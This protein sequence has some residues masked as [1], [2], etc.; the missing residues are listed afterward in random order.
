M[1][2]QLPFKDIEFAYN[3]KTLKG[4]HRTDKLRYYVLE[5]RPKFCA[6]TYDYGYCFGALERWYYDNIWKMCKKTIYSG[7]G[8]NDNNFLYRDQVSLLKDTLLLYLLFLAQAKQRLCVVQNLA[9]LK[10]LV[11]YYIYK[12]I[13]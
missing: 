12:S 4:R 11:Y 3:R 1:K 5:L 7:C 8:G 10:S 2:I 9:K 6:L 13:I